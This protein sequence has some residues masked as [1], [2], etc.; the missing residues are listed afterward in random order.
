MVLNCKKNHIRAFSN[1]QEILVLD[2]LEV[3]FPRL[4]CEML[5]LVKGLV[6]ELWIK[7]PLTS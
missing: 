4:F 6:V 5:C 1:F 7:K 3:T 2:I